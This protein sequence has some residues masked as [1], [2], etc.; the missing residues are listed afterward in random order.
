MTLSFFKNNPCKDRNNIHEAL[1]Q[2]TP[3][4]I[5]NIIL[6]SMTNIYYYYYYYFIY[7][8]FVLRCTDTWRGGFKYTHKNILWGFKALLHR[9]SF[10]RINNRQLLKTYW[11]ID[12]QFL[13]FQQCFLLNQITIPIYPY[14]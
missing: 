13:L 12:E 8:Y 5:G 4:S 6:L 7:C 11:E 10:G 9:Y 2:L 3:K 14:F 1:I